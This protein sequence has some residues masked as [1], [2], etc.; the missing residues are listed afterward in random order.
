MR[1]IFKNDFARRNVVYY[2]KKYTLKDFA[3]QII[4]EC[5]RPMTTSEIWQYGV[6]RGY[7]KKGG[8]VGKSPWVTIGRKLIIDI[9]DNP[10]SKFTVNEQ[11]RPKEFSLK[12]ISASNL[13]PIKNETKRH[14]VKFDE[15]DLHKHITYFSYT[16]L[17]RVYTRTINHLRSG[18]QDR[19]REWIHPDLVGVSFPVGIWDKELIELSKE[20]GLLPLKLYSFELKKELTSSNLR[21]Y[22][23][24]A[25]SN[26]SWAHEGYLATA[27][28]EK[29]DDFLQELK[30][31]SNSFGIGII[32]LDII[33]PDDSEVIIPAK[34]KETLDWETINKLC[35]VNPDFKDFIECVKDNAK[36]AKI[37][38]VLY[39]KIYDSDDLKLG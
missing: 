14:L 11:V 8:F 9:K 26:S 13:L 28:L 36:T 31:L 10:K 12:S 25:V 27:F 17:S 37:Q 15:R 35:N 38:K 3:E 16:Y 21:E 19:F 32:R 6:E 23:F 34:Q 7:E 2:M 39:N 24:Q 30:R 22:F 29:D 5:G 33:N 4:K 20:M 1:G 18:K